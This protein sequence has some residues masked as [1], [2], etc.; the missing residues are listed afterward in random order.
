M[1]NFKYKDGDV[2]REMKVTKGDI[3]YQFRE[4]VNNGKLPMVSWVVPPAKFSDHPSSP[5]YGAWYI[6]EVLDILTKD[7]KVWKKTVLIIT[8]DENDGY[9]DHV[10]PFVAPHPLNDNGYCQNPRAS[11][12]PL[13]YHLH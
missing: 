10:P 11:S 4:D 12:C 3:L 13:S 9:F 7:P 5:W 2:E 6:S 1:S 8:Y